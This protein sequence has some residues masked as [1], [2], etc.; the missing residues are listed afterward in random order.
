M[1]QRKKYVDYVTGGGDVQ[2]P[3]GHIVTGQPGGVP[4][5]NGYIIPGGPGPAL[6]LPTK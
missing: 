6:V 5:P 2:G 4:G 1:E 3:Y